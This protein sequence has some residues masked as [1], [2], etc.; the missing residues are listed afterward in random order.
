MGT[1]NNPGAFDC[2]A[3]AHPDEPMFILLGRDPAASLLVALWADI[4]EAMGEAKEKVAEARACASAMSEWAERL[5]KA[6]KTEEAITKF[7]V[8]TRRLLHDLDHGRREIQ[9]MASLCW[10]RVLVGDSEGEELCRNPLP[11]AD[12]PRSV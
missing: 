1:K 9:E 11:C 2:Y 5:G 6:R 4:R 12:H 7:L 3:N 10:E 8:G